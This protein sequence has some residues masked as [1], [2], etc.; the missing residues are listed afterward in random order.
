VDFVF[1]FGCFVHLDL[2][3]I[4]GYLDNLHRILTPR[5]NVVI[6]YADKTKPL[7]QRHKAFSENTPEIMLRMIRDSGFTV[8]DDNRWLMPHS[9]IVRFTPRSFGAA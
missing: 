3:I 6:H 5:A 8:Q 9:A 7:A 4:Q 1:S 2:D